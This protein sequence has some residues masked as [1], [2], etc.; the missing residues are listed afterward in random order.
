MIIHNPNGYKHIPSPNMGDEKIVPRVIV[1]H[2]T[3]TWTGAAAIRTL[4]DRN[5]KV[6]A[7]YVVDRDGTVTNLVPDHR[8][9]WHAGP[10][11]WGKYEGLNNHSI[12]IELVNIG[13]VKALATGNYIDPYGKVMKGSD[14]EKM[15]LIGFQDE[16]LGPG[17][18]YQ[19]L[20]PE[21]QLAALDKLV[22]G[23]IKNNPTIEAVVTHR[24]IDTRGWK[25]DPGPAFPL[26]RYTRLLPDRQTP[27]P[28]KPA[29]KLVVAAEAVNVRVAGNAQASLSRF[30]PLP[31]GTVV[32]ATGVNGAWTQVRFETNNG[33]AVGWIKSQ[34]LKLEPA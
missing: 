7:H 21:A 25:V 32:E 11:K 29:T 8:A 1:M 4:T 24:Q 12:G 23:L 17:A 20:Y 2:Y 33:P 34:F 27:E 9:A 26:A 14:V 19:P 31:R 16:R 6:S 10:S 30:G 18:F 15:G 13:Y 3:A 28:K 22:A 5:A